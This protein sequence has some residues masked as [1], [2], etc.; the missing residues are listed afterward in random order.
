MMPVQDA[1][2]EKVVEGPKYKV[3]GDKQ[4]HLID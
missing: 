2:F 3:M 1:K 4:L